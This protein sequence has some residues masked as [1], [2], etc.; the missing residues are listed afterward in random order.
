MSI[1][2]EDIVNVWLMFLLKPTSEKSNKLLEDINDERKF[3][4][5]NSLYDQYPDFKADN[6]NFIVWAINTNYFNDEKYKVAATTIN[7]V[8]VLLN[9]CSELSDI[10]TIEEICSEIIEYLIKNP[11]EMRNSAAYHIRLVFSFVEDKNNFE[12]QKEFAKCL[13]KCYSEIYSDYD[14]NF[15][16]NIV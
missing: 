10:K 11:K 9:Y 8:K 3:L 13:S 6:Y 16:N 5:E 4:I 1:K 7:Q 2:N 12:R 15:F 14:S